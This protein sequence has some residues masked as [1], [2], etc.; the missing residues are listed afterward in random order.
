M[1]VSVCFSARSSDKA[2]EAGVETL[3]DYRG[4]GYAIRVASSW[5]KAIRQSQRSAM[6]WSNSTTC[7][8]RLFT[9]FIQ[10]FC[11]NFFTKFFVYVI[12]VFTYCSLPCIPSNPCLQ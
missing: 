12:L 1:A 8:N 11:N 7:S 9:F 10:F 6:L 3:E 4:K 5:A 2:A